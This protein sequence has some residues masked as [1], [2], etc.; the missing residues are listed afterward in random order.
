MKQS[1]LSM[2]ASLSVEYS[3]RVLSTKHFEKSSQFPV[4]SVIL[5]HFDKKRLTI[6]SSVKK[7][8][9]SNLKMKGERRNSANEKK[10][11]VAIGEMD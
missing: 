4:S 10:N 2:S 7:Q 3:Y 9:E 11:E 6:T 5:N 1:Q 8:S